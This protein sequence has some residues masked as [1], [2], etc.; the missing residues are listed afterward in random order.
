MAGV[1]KLMYPLPLCFPAL[2]GCTDHL[3]AALA[4]GLT[5]GEHHGF[6]ERLQDSKYLF[7]WPGERAGALPRA[8]PLPELW[9]Q[10]HGGHT[11]AVTFKELEKQLV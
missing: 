7:S 8:L 6:A 3:K 10:D 4:K 11:G 2:L 9:Q 5:G 1:V